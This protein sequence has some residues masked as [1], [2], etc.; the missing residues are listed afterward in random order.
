MASVFRFAGGDGLDGRPLER[1][2]CFLIFVL[3]RES[4]PWCD[5]PCGLGQGFGIEKI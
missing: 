4:L 5:S 1:E 3:I 2:V